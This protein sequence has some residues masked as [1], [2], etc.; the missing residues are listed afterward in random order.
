[1][2]D[3]HNTICLDVDGVICE[4]ANSRECQPVEGAIDG[5]LRLINAGW[6]IE[7]YSDRC[8]TVDG[9][10][11]ICRWIERHSFGTDLYSMFV[12]HQDKIIVVKTKPTAKIYVDDRGWHFNG[13]DELT[14]EACEAFRAWWQPPDS[15]RDPNGL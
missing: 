15:T 6:Y 1:M 13:W 8:A 12:Y 4:L 3:W 7:I 9:R 5:I 2:K 14:P 10:L 11:W